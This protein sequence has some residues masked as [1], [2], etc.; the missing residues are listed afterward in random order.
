MEQHWE[1]IDLQKV[2]AELELFDDTDGT[3]RS[4]LVDEVI[5]KLKSAG[6]RHVIED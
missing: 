1:P 5:Q 6:T 2:K 4:I 3:G